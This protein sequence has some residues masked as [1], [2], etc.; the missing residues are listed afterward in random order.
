M[1]G[2][3]R[4]DREHT[5]RGMAELR[6]QLVKAMRDCLFQSAKSGMATVEIA[7]KLHADGWLTSKQ[8]KDIRSALHDEDSERCLRLAKRVG[9]SIQGAM[10]RAARWAVQT[11]EFVVQGLE[12]SVEPTTRAR[13]SRP[14]LPT[15]RIE[16]VDENGYHVRWMEVDDPRVDMCEAFNRYCG[17]GRRAIIAQ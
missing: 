12:Y 17:D 2:T 1:Q 11:G 14:R 4:Q 3:K 10:H 8:M 16:I 13:S 9:F 6:A 15:L 5:A 7:D